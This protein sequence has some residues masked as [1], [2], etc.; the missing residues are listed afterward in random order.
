MQVGTI[1][2]ITTFLVLFLTSLFIQAQTNK[3]DEL[4]RKQGEWAKYKDGVKAYEGTFIDDYP[5]GVFTRYYPSGRLMSTSNFS[6]EGKKSQTEFYYD[7]RKHSFK[8]KGN[9]LHQKKDSIWLIYNEQGA[10]VSEEN[11]KEANAQGIWKL[12]N[13]LGVIAKETPYDKGK[14]EG[15]QKEYFE[16]GQLQRLITFENDSING[17]FEV[18]YESGQIR[19]NGFFKNG[20]KDLEWIYYHPDGEI[21]FIEQYRE[22]LILKRMDTEGH[23]FEMEKENDTIHLDIDPSVIDFK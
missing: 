8:A 1:K 6:Q 3:T 21:W 9:Y 10:L 4:G 19:I 23:H 22:G 12:Y 14:I 16:N 17:L 18:Y 15:V 20:L 7:N 5:V 13:Y 2:N 11:Y